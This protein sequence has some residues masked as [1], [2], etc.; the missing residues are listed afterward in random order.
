MPQ[1]TRRP[2]AKAAPPKPA[3]KAA[4][5]R[6]AATTA[7]SKAAQAAAA[8]GRPAPAVR[9]AAASVQQ[10][11]IR[12]QDVGR[13]PANVSAADANLPAHMRADANMGKE[14]IGREDVSV[15]RLKLMQGT[16]KEIEAYS[17]LRPGMF[18]HTAA[19]HIFD[20]PFVAVPLYVSKEYILWRPLASG[21]GIIARSVDSVHWA[22][23]AGE[24]KVRLDNP[25]LNQ[26]ATWKLAPTVRESGLA[27]WGTMYAGDTN[28]PPAATLMY[29]YVFAFPEFPDLMPAVY[30]FQ[31][32]AIKAGRALNTKLKTVRTPLF[33]TA[34]TVSA[35]KATNAS[36]NEYFV[37]DVV[38]AGLVGVDV[39]TP[40]LYAAYKQSY[41]Q[42]SEQGMQIKDIDTLQTEG[43]GG[44]GGQ[45]NGA[46]PNY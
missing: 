35:A 43:D 32:A 39:G 12:P 18:F 30:T 44:V 21:G 17:E 33:G 9:P 24:F 14:N 6:P 10:Q 1:A 29:N 15:P 45:P 41:G 26:E 8:Q 16:S 19:E 28:S 7:S 31:R 3:P 38:G 22:P 25:Y 4:P 2:A 36:G 20:E 23:G 27:E 46:T 11:T 42:F 40:E 37:P 34:W 5:V 13:L